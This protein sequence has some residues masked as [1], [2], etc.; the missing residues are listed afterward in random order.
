MKM[1][2]RRERIQVI[3]GFLSG[4]VLPNIG[5]FI[6]WGLITALFIPTGW[7]PNEQLALLVGPM[8]KYLL[9]LLI[10][11]T[12]GKAVAGER[13]GV[14]GTIA[15]MGVIVGADIPMFLG[16]M[17][18]GPLSGY[19]IKK[20]DKLVEGRVPAGFEMLVNNFSIG[21]IGMLLALL[22]YEG[23][24]PVIQEVNKLL[25]EGI[26]FLVKAGYLPLLS[27]VNEP[28]KVLFLNNAIEQGIYAPLGLQD[29]LANGGK[30][31]FFMLETSPG[32]GLGVLLAFWL[33]GKGASKTSAPTAV[34]IHFFGGI[35]EIYFPYVLMKPLMI[36]PMILGGMAGVITFMFFN[37]GLVAFPSPGS[38]FSYLAMT[39]RGGFTGTIAGV[40][41]G[42]A[43][44]FVISA[45][46]L[47]LTGSAN[48]DFETSKSKSREMKLK[49]K[50]QPSP[51]PVNSVS[52][53]GATDSIRKI[54][55]ACD[56]GMGSSAM[57][58]GML[59]KKVKEAGLTH[60]SVTNSAVNSLH[61]D[62]DLVI[63]HRDLTDNAR[64][65]APGAHHLS[66]TNFLDS[67]FYAALVKKL[68]QGSSL[69]ENVLT[70]AEEPA[71]FT[72]SENHIFL[73]LKA[74]NKEQAIRFAGEQL[75]K[76]G[77]AEPEYVDAMLEREKLT[78]TYLGESI[79]VPHGTIEAKD[80]VI[81]TGIVICQYP[82]GV[83][84]GEGDDDIARI[85]I[86]IAARNNEHIQVIT[87]LTN[88]L[89]DEAAIKQLAETSD[90]QL[91]LHL[92]GPEK[93]A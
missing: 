45:V 77:Y 46:I 35:H 17:A 79:A 6:A 21:I 58:A 62:E 31:I 9:P 56:A 48:E 36:I 57:G 7:I 92:L 5:A 82:D 22:A 42:T 67:D 88:A 39:P 33:F 1:T 75:V 10:G 51:V 61:G 13:G 19:I 15:T 43:V 20:F 29:S 28:A 27:I 71:L 54:V 66:L 78:P 41:V 81:N 18:L 23:I 87:G 44:S 68:Q 14:I 73:G 12:G 40:V 70:E 89:D 72:L 64:R 26:Q 2:G 60:L 4:M 55:V 16:A 65:V 90:K 32:P 8:I 59:R 53:L 83:K 93:A 47:K 85:V 34:I 86:G 11:Y 69:P 76:G 50:P 38:I 80:R 52:G 84:F 25:M 30:S 49:G 91:V 37:A 63:T 74:S 3:G 24:G